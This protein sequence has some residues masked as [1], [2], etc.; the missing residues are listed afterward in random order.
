R[1]PRP[2]LQHIELADQRVTLHLA[3]PAAPPPGWG[4]TDD[5]WTFE[6]G[7]PLPDP[8][9][10]APWPLLCTIGATDDGH[11]VLANLEELGTITLTGDQDAATALARSMTAELTLS[12]W[13]ILTD[14][15]TVGVAAELSDLDPVRLH[16]H[17]P[18]DVGFLACL[19]A[20]LA[21]RGEDEPEMFHAV[22]AS[23]LKAAEPLI[24]VIADST[25][26]LGATVVTASGDS[27]VTDAVSFHLT[28]DGRLHI[29]DLGLDL[30]SAG[31]TAAEA[32]ATAAI[33]AVTRDAVPGPPPAH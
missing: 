8:E 18:D 12:P 32:A 22:I 15:D 4:G 25:G 19:T 7:Q 14:I 20:D 33:V 3:E 17:E 11:L 23:E 2:H 16:H 26:R 5:A 29:Q 9:S 13:S 10:P 30:A 28:E 21:S 6:L 24:R 31:L 1:Q 27:P